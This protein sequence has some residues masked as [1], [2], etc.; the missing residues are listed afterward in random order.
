M[1][2]RE[3]G[4]VCQVRQEHSQDM[5]GENLPSAKAPWAKGTQEA[6]LVE[7]VSVNFSQRC[8]ITAEQIGS[9]S[10]HAQHD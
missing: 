6:C 7:A 1:K 2:H 9:K 5:K 10:F 8:K 3:C 4:T